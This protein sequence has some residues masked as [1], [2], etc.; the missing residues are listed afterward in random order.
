MTDD[1]AAIA[2]AIIDGNRYMVLGT[3]DADGIPWASPVW[4]ATED[5]REFL[6]VSAPAARHSRNLAVR[7]ELGIVIFD[8]TVAPNAGQAV[9]MSATATE[10]RGDDIDA[11][12]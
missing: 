10:L 2:R 6:W 8:S 7:P 5:R 4:F 3:A 12:V 9:Y 11:G 1:T